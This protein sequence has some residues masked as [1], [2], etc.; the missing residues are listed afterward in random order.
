M[1]WTDFW[2]KTSRDNPSNSMQH[3]APSYD[4][5]DHHWITV[6]ENE[7]LSPTHSFPPSVVSDE[8][9]DNWPQAP[10]P[11]P[12]PFTPL[13]SC[14]TPY[15]DNVCF[16]NNETTPEKDIKVSSNRIDEE[17][18]NSNLMFGDLFDEDSS[19]LQ[20]L[21]D[22]IN[23]AANNNTYNTTFNESNS[24]HCNLN[25]TFIYDPPE[26]PEKEQPSHEP[27]TLNRKRKYSS[28]DQSAI[29]SEMTS[30]PTN[31]LSPRENQE[32][33]HFGRHDVFIPDDVY[34]LYDVDEAQLEHENQLEES[35]RKR[36]RRGSTADHTC[37]N[38]T[39][40]LPTTSSLH[41]IPTFGLP[42]NTTFDLLQKPTSSIYTSEY[43]VPVS[44]ATS[45]VTPSL[46]PAETPTSTSQ[47]DHITTSAQ[48][49]E[50][51]FSEK[52]FT[53][54]FSS[55][56]ETQEAHNPH[57]VMSY[58]QFNNT[59]SIAQANNETAPSKSAWESRITHTEENPNQTPVPTSA[60]DANVDGIHSL[61]LDQVDPTLAAATIQ[62]LNTGNELPMVKYELKQKILLNIN[63]KGK[64]DVIL[65]DPT[66]KEYV[67]SH[68]GWIY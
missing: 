47:I 66:P 3:Q 1:I 19:N 56:T 65:D 12:S 28:L 41:Q 38:T 63:L 18:E 49:L 23:N 20:Q 2:T 46:P 27:T 61:N 34:P 24:A 60:A 35:L 48:F 5:D 58:E 52:L 64:G 57:R 16:F 14:H 32:I 55:N 36:F 37:P 29:T 40:T 6:D 4:D 21:L 51:P 39:Y 9:Y 45:Y 26:I 8:R 31:A 62:F 10:T 42:Q 11:S 15:P 67:V 44:P 53:S 54:A 7:V 59:Q 25:S 50:P 13:P 43:Y 17:D 33:V 30:W 22:L 68:G